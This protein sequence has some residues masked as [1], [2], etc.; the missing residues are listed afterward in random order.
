MK[1]FKSC[2]H[3]LRY[4]AILTD[5]KI[6]RFIIALLD[7]KDY[8]VVFLREWMEDPFVEGDY[9]SLY[10]NE[11]AISQAE[12]IMNQLKAGNTRKAR[13][14]QKNI[15]GTKSLTVMEWAL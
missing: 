10:G 12:E 15:S 8:P 11:L 13:S 9:Y 1:M 6:R 14:M 4:A 2:T 5:Y 3:H 7:T